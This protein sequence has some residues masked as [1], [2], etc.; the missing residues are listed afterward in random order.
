[1]TPRWEWR[2]IPTRYDT[3]TRQWAAKCDGQTVGHYRTTTYAPTSQIAWAAWHR[4]RLVGYYPTAEA[5]REAIMAAERRGGA[6]LR[7]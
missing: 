5:A 4:Q 6:G 1:M 2:A 3:S 7:P